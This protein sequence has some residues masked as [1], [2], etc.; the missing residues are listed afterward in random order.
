[1]A[2]FHTSVSMVS[3]GKGKSLAQKAAYIC[4]KNVFDEYCGVKRY[5]YRKDVVYHKIFLPPDAPNEFSDLQKL[6]TAIDESEKRKDA[7]TAREIIFSLPVELSCDNRI[8]L[9]QKCVSE[10]WVSR[11]MCAILALHNAGT[12]NPHA[13][14]LLT[15]RKVSPDGFDVRKNREWNQKNLYHAWRKY[16][17]KTLNLE[18]KRKGLN[19]KVSDESNFLQG[20]NQKPTRYLGA[21]A[22]A[23]QKKGILTDRALENL[24][25]REKQRQKELEREA[26]I[27]HKKHRSK[28]F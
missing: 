9:A 22:S 11:G 8:D 14:T 18:F 28:H 17:A 5:N 25:I 23:L 15:T 26:K 10:F 20:I 13:H 7:Q 24:A 3:R 16:L 21:S 4:G 6:I 2:I 12:G 27:Q 19:I 1:M